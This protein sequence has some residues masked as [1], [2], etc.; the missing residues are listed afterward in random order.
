MKA[1]KCDLK[2]DELNKKENISGKLKQIIKIK[3]GLHRTQ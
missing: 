2:I 3:T 1:Y